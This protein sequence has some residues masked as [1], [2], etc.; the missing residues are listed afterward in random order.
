MDDGP[1]AGTFPRRQSSPGRRERGS[2]IEASGASPEPASDAV[3]L[4]RVL[5]HGDSFFPAGG[6]AFSWGLEGLIADGSVGDAEGVERF[7]RAQL[8]ARWAECDRV[9][10]HAAYRHEC[11]APTLRAMERDLEALAWA[12]ELR[13]GSRRA[14]GA[15]LGAHRK[16][17]NAA[18]AR[19]HERVRDG[20]HLG[21]LPLVQGIVWRGA[22]LARE[23]AI[24]LSAH[25]LCVG[26]L[27]AAIRLG[28][29]GHVESQTILARLQPSIG[30]LLDS[31]PPDFVSS[32]A[33]ATE[34]AAMHHE[35]QPARL[36]AN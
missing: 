5:Q 23:D 11:G 32:Y 10:V 8:E 34:I 2:R 4:L 14:G 12:R 27:G 36:F 28:R 31:P 7:L 25:V 24:A 20:T 33:P 30:A 3:R 26:V 9:I 18:A 22:G 16:L 19:L 6:T 13:D 17:G 15:L 35:T 29:L 1:P 21:H